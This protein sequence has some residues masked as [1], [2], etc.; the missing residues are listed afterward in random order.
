MHEKQ[1][2]DK[3]ELQG[4]QIQPQLHTRHAALHGAFL[5][6]ALGVRA[7]SIA[8]GTTSNPK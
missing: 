8:L 1:Y 4:G 3:Q 7:V 6:Q 5:P 2:S